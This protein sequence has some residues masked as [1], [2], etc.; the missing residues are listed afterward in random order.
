MRSTLSALNARTNLIRI[1]PA[2]TNRHVTAT[3]R[4]LSVNYAGAICPATHLLLDVAW[5]G[6][7]ITLDDQPIRYFR[8]WCVVSLLVRSYG[9]VEERSVHT[10]K[11]AGSIPAR[12]TAVTAARCL[13]AVFL[14]PSCFGRVK[15]VSNQSWWAGNFWHPWAD[16]SAK[17]DRGPHSSARPRKGEP[18]VATPFPAHTAKT[19]RI[20]N[21]WRDR[22]TCRV[23][24]SNGK[25][26]RFSDRWQS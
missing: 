20:G 25:C 12:T 17:R 10:G 24:S 4:G 15:G 18:L 5:P 9:S 6:V 2:V 19:V 21:R 22:R 3:F 14:L 16:Y 8:F 23:G 13:A 26:S 11:V 1:L 7:P